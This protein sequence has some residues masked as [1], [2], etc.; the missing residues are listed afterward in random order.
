[1]HLR[2]HEVGVAL[3]TRPHSTIIQPSRTAPIAI[4]ESANSTIPIIAHQTP[5]NSPQKS[6]PSESVLQENQLVSFMI[7]I[8][9]TN[10]P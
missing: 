4:P 5:T 2:E 1:M 10:T 9:E 8:C 3:P 6:S 7:F